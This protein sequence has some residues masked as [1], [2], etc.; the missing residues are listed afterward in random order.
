MADLKLRD[1]DGI[2]TDEGLI[3]RVFG[4]SHPPSAYICD[5]EYASEKIF[6]SKDPR[7]PRTGGNQAF[8]KF[9]DDEGLKFVFKHYPKYVIH[10]QMLEQ[11]ILG[12]DERDI[13]Q[14]RKP[15]DRLQQLIKSGPRDD[16]EDA[17]LRV[18]ATVMDDSRTSSEAFG[19]FGSM[20][21]GFHHPKFSDIDLIV[22]GRQE[23]AQVRSTL[24]DLYNESSSG[25]SNEFRT[26]EAMRGKS[27]RFKNFTVDE[28]LWHQKRKLIYGLYQD[29]LSG[30]TI[31][32]EFEPVKKCSEIV[33]EF[34][35]VVKIKRKG[36]VRVQAKVTDD[37]DGSF[38]PSIYGIKP[39]RVLSGTGDAAE[40][41]RIVSYM[42][43]FRLQVQ[44]DEEILVE[45]TL[46]EVAGPNGSFIK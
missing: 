32:A 37:S 14:A 45:G 31:K 21:H 1:R 17:T 29:K 20:L 30:R 41:M 7:A 22:Y 44:K 15:E 40:A 5:A 27:W 36:W 12:I 43:E 35:P 42:E 38:I 13:K 9:Y 16:L 10:H 3:F 4:Y 23:I 8:F 11:D 18:L 19:I 2:L 25:F 34:D 28:F 6:K 39:F 33:S 26:D 46:E 24:D